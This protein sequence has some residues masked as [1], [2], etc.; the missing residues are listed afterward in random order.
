M[1]H[2]EF[3]PLLEELVEKH[4]SFWRYHGEIMMYTYNHIYICIC[5]YIYINKYVYIYIYMYMCI[6]IYMYTTIHDNLV[7]LWKSTGL[8]I[9]DVW[10]FGDDSPL[11]SFQ[12]RHP[13]DGQFWDQICTT[14]NQR[15]PTIL[16]DIIK[17]R[18]GR[19]T[20]YIWN[21]KNVW[22]HQPV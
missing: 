8:K 3:H 11:A 4:K 13:T 12:W 15:N 6:Y 19:M 2:V 5:I 18:M 22:N 16:D 10:P 20:S 17:G 21:G 9:A 14:K 7:E 1:H